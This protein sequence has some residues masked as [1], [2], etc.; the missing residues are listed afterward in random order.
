MF[1]ILMAILNAFI[2]AVSIFRFFG[3]QVTYLA[4]NISWAASEIGQLPDLF[5]DFLKPFVA[6]ALCLAIVA[7]VVKLV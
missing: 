7:I 6:V 5:P 3:R 1:A 4:E 2:T